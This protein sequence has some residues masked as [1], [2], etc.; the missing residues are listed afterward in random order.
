[1]TG[2]GNIIPLV[3]P[4]DRT[5]LDDFSTSPNLSSWS[6]ANLRSTALFLVA[7]SNETI[8]RAP[9]ASDTAPLDEIAPM[10]GLTFQELAV[11]AFER[12]GAETD[13]NRP[14]EA[15][16]SSFHF[17]RPVDSLERPGG[18]GRAVYG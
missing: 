13:V 11:I 18:A 7:L 16:E 5:A 2:G 1:M 17:P 15:P 9:R 10:T 12:M 4:V 6:L 14:G 8:A 3:R